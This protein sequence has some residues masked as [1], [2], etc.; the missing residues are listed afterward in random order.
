VLGNTF[1]IFEELTALGM[2][3]LQVVVSKVDDERLV[4]VEFWM[5]NLISGHF[6]LQMFH[7]LAFVKELER[8][9]LFS[10]R[11]SWLNPAISQG[12]LDLFFECN[13]RRNTQQMV[14]F[15]QDFPSSVILWCWIVF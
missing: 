10:L 15:W 2:R 6:I 9:Q 4:A 5:N 13:P 8:A 1:F 7:W 11:S 12:R 3:T 14:P